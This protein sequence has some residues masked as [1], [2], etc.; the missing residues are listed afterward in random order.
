MFKAF[1]AALIGATMLTCASASAAPGSYAFFE[2]DPH[3][4]VEAIY[5][6]KNPDG[7]FTV[8]VKV[9]NGGAKSRAN[10]LHL[11][12][13]VHFYGSDGSELLNVSGHVWAEGTFFGSGK[14]KIFPFNVAKPGLWDAVAKMTITAVQ[15]P[16]AGAPSA[17]M[18]TI[19][20]WN[21]G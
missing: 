3:R 15:E 1:K 18:I 20:K 17:P 19:L 11:R 8:N 13:T 10:P 21:L 4:F 2:I 7:S 6:T 5:P 16:P 14:D 12:A 9:S